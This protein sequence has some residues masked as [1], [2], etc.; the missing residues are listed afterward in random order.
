MV[1]MPRKEV[2]PPLE[3]V[4][5]RIE[6][7]LPPE[8]KERI[9]S[10]GV[11][12]IDTRDAERYEKGHVEG[13]ISLPAGESGRD[14]HAEDY[15]A[16]VDEVAGGRDGELIL[17]CGEGNRSARTADALR[18]E[19]GFE[20][21]VSVVGGLKLWDDLGYPIEGELAAG[22]DEDEVSMMGLDDDGDKT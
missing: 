2:P 14:A 16:A 22:A 4:K 3:L 11:V 7:V 12:V 18:N 21:V 1:D 8:A 9:E 20:K 5:E 10:G 13:A 19:H 6:E 15:A 17:F